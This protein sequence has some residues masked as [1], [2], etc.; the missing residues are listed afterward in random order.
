MT[1]DHEQVLRTARLMIRQG[2]A[3]TA[4]EVPDEASELDINFACAVRQKVDELIS[5]G[6]QPEPMPPLGNPT[7]QPDG[8]IEFLA[9]SREIVERARVAHTS[10]AIEDWLF[11]NADGEDEK[12][13][14]RVVEVRPVY[15][16]LFFTV[17]LANGS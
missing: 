9:T 14:G 8:S 6:Y 2:I 17:R 11:F 15:N 4:G 13:T 7:I 16:M 3:H 12:V 1:I 5:E 10:G